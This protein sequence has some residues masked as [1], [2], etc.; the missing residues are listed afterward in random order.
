MD[1]ALM[2]ELEEIDDG[3]EPSSFWNIF[4]GGARRGP[5]G[6]ADH[7]RLKP[8]YDKY[9]G[10]LFKSDLADRKQVWLTVFF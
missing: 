6:S 3:A 7:W 1:L 4:E 10:R 2:G 9:C 5:L 8:G